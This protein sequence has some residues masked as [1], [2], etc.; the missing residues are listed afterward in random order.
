MIQPVKGH[1]GHQ[2]TRQFYLT[3]RFL[4]LVTHFVDIAAGIYQLYSLKMTLC[5][6]KHVGVTYCVNKVVT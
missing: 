1:P 6:L 2:I 5:G 3:S 4:H